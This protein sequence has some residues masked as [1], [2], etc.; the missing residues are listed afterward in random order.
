MMETELAAKKPSKKKK[1]KEVEKKINLRRR[2][3]DIEEQR[4]WDKEWNY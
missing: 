2:I 3:E 4:Q 1:N